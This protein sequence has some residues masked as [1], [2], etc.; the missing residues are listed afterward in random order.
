MAA[1]G[2]RRERAARLP[3][4][5]R[6]RHIRDFIMQHHM[7]A[8]VVRDHRGL[9][10][11]S[12]RCASGSRHGSP[13][14]MARLGLPG[15]PS[16]AAASQVY[17]S[18]SASISYLAI[19]AGTI[20]RPTSSMPRSEHEAREE[21]SPCGGTLSHHRW[22]RQ[23]SGR[24]P[25]GQPHP[26]FEQDIRQALGSRAGSRTPFAIPAKAGSLPPNMSVSA[27]PACAGSPAPQV[28]LGKV[29]Q[30]T[31]SQRREAPGPDLMS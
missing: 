31:L 7:I 8:G 28:S 27:P 3:A 17:P 20:R 15:R 13:R 29:V 16:S 6:H 2:R 11:R 1:C 14:P 30:P 26:A 22:H 25:S 12:P 10:Q 24:I 19:H 5:L 21:S 9:V 23:R 4:H 18:G